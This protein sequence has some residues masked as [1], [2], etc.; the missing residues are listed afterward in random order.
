MKRFI[1]FILL[2]VLMVCLSAC[3]KREAESLHS[4][5]SVETVPPAK[6]T[7]PKASSS[8]ST[9]SPAHSVATSVPS[10]DGSHLQEAQ[11]SIARI[12]GGLSE[13]EEV[14]DFVLP[15]SIEIRT[16]DFTSGDSV[17]YSLFLTMNQI[18]RSYNWLFTQTHNPEIIFSADNQNL[19]QAIFYIK[20]YAN[21][22]S[23]SRDELKAMLEEYIDVFCK[24]FPSAYP[25]MSIDR[26]IFCW[27]LPSINETSLYG[28]SYSCDSKHG[29][30]VRGEGSGLLY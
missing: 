6:K 17:V 1:A 19:E 25:N 22:E 23:L 21:V 8:V 28:A 12:T 26:L 27:Q 18:P 30:L 20:L 3:G 4:S 16:E 14:D 9:P 2:F 5:I 7:P 15:E 13:K 11:D 10:K 24:I 29:K